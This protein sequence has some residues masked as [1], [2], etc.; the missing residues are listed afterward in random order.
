MPSAESSARACSSFARLASGAVNQNNQDST[1]NGQPVCEPP[2]VAPMVAPGAAASA[3]PTTVSTTD[4]QR[5]QATY[6]QER[7][8]MVTK[9]PLTRQSTAQQRWWALSM[10][11]PELV[12]AHRARQRVEARRKQA[13]PAVVLPDVSGLM[14]WRTLAVVFRWPGFGK[15]TVP[16]YYC[17]VC[18]CNEPLSEGLTL[19]ACGHTF[20]KVCNEA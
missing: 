20:C 8:Q 18:M 4:T 19:P 15:V 1:T 14:R 16:T 13:P 10:M 2:A 3:A 17:E 6:G 7:T 9:P 11:M 5:T 12:S